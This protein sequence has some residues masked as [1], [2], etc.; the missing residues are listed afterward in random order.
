M[1]MLPEALA[2]APL[3]VNPSQPASVDPLDRARVLVGA[4]FDFKAEFEG[5]VKQSARPP[6]VGTRA[7]RCLDERGGP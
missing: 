7:E 5:N 2:V 6:H 3:P 4:P 1:R